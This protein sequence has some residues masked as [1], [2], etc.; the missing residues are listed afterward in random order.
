L[1]LL[2]NKVNP[3]SGHSQ[4]SELQAR[5]GSSLKLRMR[6]NGCTFLQS[7]VNLKFRSRFLVKQSMRSKSSLVISTTTPFTSKVRKP[8][9]AAEK[10]TVRAS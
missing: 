5:V 7:A 1:D 10:M 6:V 4:K 8:T 3:F 9:S 2:P